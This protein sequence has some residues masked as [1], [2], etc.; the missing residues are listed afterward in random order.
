[1]GQQ[2]FQAE[3]IAIESGQMRSGLV[4]VYFQL[5]SSYTARRSG[6]ESPHQ[7]LPSVAVPQILLEWIAFVVIPATA[8]KFQVTVLPM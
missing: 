5:G 6:K 7:G 4:S 3:M 2:N 1:L 8:L